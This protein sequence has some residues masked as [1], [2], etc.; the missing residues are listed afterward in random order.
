VTAA[1]GY[2][3]GHIV[4][5]DATSDRSWSSVYGAVPNLAG[6]LVSLILRRDYFTLH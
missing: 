6:V 3:G 2:R 5:P 4:I 1:K